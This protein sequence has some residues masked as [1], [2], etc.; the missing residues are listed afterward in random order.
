MAPGAPTIGPLLQA[1]RALPIVFIGVADPIGGGFVE[2]LARPGGNATGFSLSD[3]G[4]SGKWLELLKEMAPQ[5]TRV[6]VIRD[7]AMATGI[8]Q[9]GAIQSAAP[10]LGMELTAVGVREAG[11][12]ER[13]L[14]AFARSSNGGMIVTGS[15]LANIHSDLIVRLAAQLKLPAVYPF[16]FYVVSGGL[17]CYGPD[18]VDQYRRQGA[19]HHHSTFNP[20]HRRRD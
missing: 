20:R 5:V 11:E 7:P 18:L 10:L 13:A 16:R 4:I 17:I 1:T 19:G 14:A 6:A 8:G 15:T 12:I 3:Y 2:S 9:W